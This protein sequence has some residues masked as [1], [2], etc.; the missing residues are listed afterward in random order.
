MYVKTHTNE[1][2]SLLLEKSLKS[3]ILVHITSVTLFLYA[4]HAFIEDL[5]KTF[6]FFLGSPRLSAASV[7]TRGICHVGSTM[8]SGCCAV[9]WGGV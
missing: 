9:V 1:N 5:V 7:D 6:L 3:Y 4:R 2:L 8:E